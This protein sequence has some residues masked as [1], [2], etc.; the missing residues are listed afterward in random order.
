MTLGSEGVPALVKKKTDDG[1]AT[2]PNV[3]GLTLVGQWVYKNVDI[4]VN[5]EKASDENNTVT[6]EGTYGM[7]FDKTITAK[8]S[9]D[10]IASPEIVLSDMNDM[11]TK[12]GQYSLGI[13]SQSDSFQISGIPNNVVDETY[14]FTIKDQ[15]NPDANLTYT[16]HIKINP[17]SV[18]IGT[19]YDYAGN[20][21]TKEYDASDTIPVQTTANVQAVGMYSHPDCIQTERLQVTFESTAKILQ[22]MV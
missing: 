7:P 14:T 12:L 6:I 2:N 4:Y 1:L 16:L 10:G 22:P 9:Y 8:Y 19:V 13:L 18:T 5:R 11:G 17:L 3:E 20:A 21:L 15:N